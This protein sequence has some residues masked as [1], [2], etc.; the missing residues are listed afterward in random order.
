MLRCLFIIVHYYI[1]FIIFRLLFV[2]F[3]AVY[4]S[5]LRDEYSYKV[6]KLRAKSAV[7]WTETLDWITY[8]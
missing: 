6:G 8:C 5:F 7:L 2:V 1:I 4:E 3:A